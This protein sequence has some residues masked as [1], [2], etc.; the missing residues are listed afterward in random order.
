M[1]SPGWSASATPT[2]SP[3]PIILSQTFSY[4]G[5]AE[6]FTI[7]AIGAGNLLVTIEAWG[8]E[9]GN[10]G[11]PAW[12]GGLG[13]Y[14]KGTFELQSGQVLDV[15]VGRQG[16]NGDLAGG[17]GGGSGVSSG[18]T[19]LVVAGGGGGAHRAFP[20]IFE[21]GPGGT[22]EERREEWRRVVEVVGCPPSD[23]VAPI[24]GEGAA[25][26]V[27]DGSDTLLSRGGKGSLVLT[28]STGESGLCFGPVA[29]V[30][31]LGGGGGTC[32]I[33][34]SDPSLVGG[35]GGGGYFGG[36]GGGRGPGGG[37][38]SFN[39]GWNQSNR[40]PGL[41]Y[42]DFEGSIRPLWRGNGQVRI[43]TGFTSQ[44]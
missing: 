7:P 42:L 4:T 41:R 33:N 43:T 9:G 31:G 27:G 16:M 18:G 22:D 44:N 28:G 13:A 35:G 37:G 10:A 26:V 40:P 34:P 14:I 32:P 30:F 38:G 24:F 15:V 17:G 36:I 23:A 8:G 25:S 19:A 3:T 39:G 29:G 12:P 1:N 6:T 5:S 20:C 21:I 2:P 11:G